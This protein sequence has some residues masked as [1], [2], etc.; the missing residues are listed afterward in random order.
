MPRLRRARPASRRCGSAVC[1]SSS[2]RS[3]SRSTRTGRGG[4]AERP[5]QG[6][7]AGR[8][9]AAAV[10]GG[11]GG[12]RQRV[13][14]DV[15]GSECA[16]PTI[17]QSRMRAQEA[18][19]VPPVL[20]RVHVSHRS[21]GNRAIARGRRLGGDDI[22]LPDGSLLGAGRLDLEG[23][24]GRAAPGD[25]GAGHDRGGQQL[26]RPAPRHHRS[27][28][29]R[30][31]ATVAK[32]LEQAAQATWTWPSRTSRSCATSSPTPRRCRRD[33]ARSLR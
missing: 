1:A 32:A 10:A 15:R 11:L 19:A 33:R 6:R 13:R 28:R 25:G 4:Q 7:G 18:C 14:R 24:R 8:L 20:L 26:R 2:R 5:G 12:V 30:Q 22:V 3:T 23:R 27:C 17:A 21:G 9:R 31:E 29:A 16:W